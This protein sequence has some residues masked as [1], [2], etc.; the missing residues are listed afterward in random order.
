MQGLSM[1]MQSQMGGSTGYEHKGDGIESW[2]EDLRT[3]L[4]SATSP[5]ELQAMVEQVGYKMMADFGLSTE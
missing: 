3:K 2:V 4:M 1:A 5:E